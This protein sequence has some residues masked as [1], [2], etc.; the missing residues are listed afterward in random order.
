MRDGNF[1]LGPGAVRLH[2]QVRWQELWPRWVR[3]GLRSGRFALDLLFRWGGLL[4]R[5]GLHR[6]PNRDA[7]HC[8]RWQLRLGEQV[9]VLQWRPVLGA[10]RSQAWRRRN[11]LRR[12]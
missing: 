6:G 11:G 5:L 9:G 10:L 1:L 12:R 7:V 2:S 3:G 8:S 4:L